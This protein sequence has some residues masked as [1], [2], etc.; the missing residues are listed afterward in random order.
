MGSTPLAKEVGSKPDSYLQKTDH[1][2]NIQPGEIVT[3]AH[4][5]PHR[6]FMN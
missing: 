1:F 3:P 6:V 2:E 5:C 4:A